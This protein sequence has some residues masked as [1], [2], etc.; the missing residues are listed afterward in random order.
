M[1]DGRRVAAPGDLRL[2]IGAHHEAGHVVVA[3]AL[4]LRLRS[5][6]IMVDTAAEG[7]GCYCKEPGE[8]DT[9]RERV[10]VATF[11]GCFA[12]NRF[13]QEQLSLPPLDYFSIIWSLDWW[14]ARGIA[15]K[16]SNTYLAGRSVSAIQDEL[17]QQSKDIVAENWP[18]IEAV[19]SSLLAQAWEPTKPLNSG[20]EWSTQSMA[21][22]ISGER[23]AE[24]LKRFSIT[25]VCVPEC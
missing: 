7:L 23:V 21:K 20:K 13:R 1:A 12:E 10:M 11:A 19:A 15:T 25:A 17:E 22:C 18:T 14:E 16:L 3:G 24:I 5:E 4:G 6:G 2:T 8:S 9:L